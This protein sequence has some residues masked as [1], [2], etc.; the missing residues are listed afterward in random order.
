[1][2]PS[3]D[4]LIDSSIGSERNPEYLFG[5]GAHRLTG[6]ARDGPY[7]LSEQPEVLIPFLS[8]YDCVVDY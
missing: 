1:M 6:E 8:P 7:G 5:G 2:L 4:L 3:I